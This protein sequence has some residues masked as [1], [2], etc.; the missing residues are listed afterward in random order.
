M[1]NDERCARCIAFKGKNGA[2]RVAVIAAVV[3]CRLY[4]PSVPGMDTV[5]IAY[6]AGERRVRNGNFRAAFQIDY[7]QL[8]SCPYGFSY[9]IPQSGIYFQY[10]LSSER[11]CIASAMCAGSML[12]LSSRSAIVLATRRIL[13]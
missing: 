9:I 6:R 4:E 12:S 13:S 10:F 8:L 2:S 11:Y 7:F 3:N 5:K 1:R